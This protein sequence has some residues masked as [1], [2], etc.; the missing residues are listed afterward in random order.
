MGSIQPVQD[1][2][3]T[4]STSDDYHVIMTI[5]DNVILNQGPMKEPIYFKK[6]TSYELCIEYQQPKTSFSDIL[7]EFQLFWGIHNKKST[8]IQKDCLVFPDISVNKTR[9]SS[10]IPEISL[11]EMEKN[12]ILYKNKISRDSDGDGIYDDLET[13][14][15]VADGLGRIVAWDEDIHGQDTKYTKYT[16]NPSRA[17]TAKDPYSDLE[18]AI[19]YMPASVNTV[20]QHPLV[21][22]IPEISVDMESFDIIRLSSSG[23]DTSN[24]IS[25]NTSTSDTESFSWGL[26]ESLDLGFEGGFIPNVSV[27]VSSHQ[28]WS[29]ST[30]ST[31][32]NGTSESWSSSLHWETGSA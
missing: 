22:A 25:Q 32:D 21:A 7:V 5:N 12:P 30:T 11:F 27:N 28:D 15:Y 23:T 3:Y 8:F 13:N 2:E 16:S 29:N 31:F 10:L 14:G 6:G 19:N 26:S 18:K 9:K 1:G 17:N 4:F 20:A 24:S